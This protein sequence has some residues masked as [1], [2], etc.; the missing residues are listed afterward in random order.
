MAA[1]SGSRAMN[2]PPIVIAMSSTPSR[3]HH[4]VKVMGYETGR[5]KQRWA[6]S[7]AHAR[8]WSDV[9]VWVRPGRFGSVRGAEVVA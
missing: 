2:E 5:T 4:R 1:L 9:Y 8:I 6:N 3:M 7:L